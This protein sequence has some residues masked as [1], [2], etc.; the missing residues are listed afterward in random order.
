MPVTLA[1]HTA[2]AWR[3]PATS[4][5]RKIWTPC[6]AAA[7]AAAK[8][9]GSR[10]RGLSPPLAPRMKRLREAPTRSGHP[11]PMQQAEI[12]EEREIVRHG[13]AEA[14]SRVGG[15][16]RGLDASGARRGDALLEIIEDLEHDLVIGRIV[17]HGLGLA[18]GMHED[19]RRAPSRRPR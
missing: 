16:A 3:V 7:M 1:C 2:S 6:A 8:D 15:D 11:K 5:T 17:L 18:L 19:R 12:G 14:D 13:L 4:C 9:P 10:A